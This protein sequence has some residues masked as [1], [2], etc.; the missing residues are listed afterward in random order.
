[1][2]RLP[3]LAV[4]SVSTVTAAPRILRIGLVVAVLSL[5]LGVA[6]GVGGPVAHAEAASVHDTT[7]SMITPNTPV[8]CLA[9][10]IGHGG[11]LTLPN[12]WGSLEVFLYAA[13]DPDSNLSCHDQWA[14][15][16]LILHHGAP[17][18]TLTSSVSDCNPAH[19]AKVRSELVEG[20]APG[21]S[22]EYQ[23]NSTNEDYLQ[24]MGSAQYTPYTGTYHY[25]LHTG[26]PYI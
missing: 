9:Y 13:Y 24:A 20:G 18:G 11:P 3:R 1:M 16:Q 15:A 21:K 26:C 19:K 14:M 7:I 6:L 17:Q 12:G 22:N 8:G 2:I 4:A 10:Q 23:F 25:S 5:A